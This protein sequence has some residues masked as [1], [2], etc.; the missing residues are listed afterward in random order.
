MDGWKRR[1]TGKAGNDGLNGSN[2]SGQAKG[3]GNGREQAMGAIGERQLLI[4]V[5]VCANHTFD[6]LLAELPETAT[7]TSAINPSC[8]AGLLLTW[9]D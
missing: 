7:T 9:P 2:E 8:L 4:C 6:E 5:C 1:T 3:G